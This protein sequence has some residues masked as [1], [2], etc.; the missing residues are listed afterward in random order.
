MKKIGLVFIIIL[1]ALSNVVAQTQSIVITNQADSISI[2]DNLGELVAKLI[3]PNT[4]SYTHLRP[5]RPY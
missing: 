5:T 1:A 4:V 3:W 2:Y